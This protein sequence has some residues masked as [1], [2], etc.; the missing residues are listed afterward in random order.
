MYDSKFFF[1]GLCKVFRH[2]CNAYILESSSLFCVRRS[3]SKVPPEI[4][5]I[6]IIFITGCFN[7]HIST[8]LNGSL[9]V[10]ISTHKHVVTCSKVDTFLSVCPNQY[11]NLEMRTVCYTTSYNLW[12]YIDN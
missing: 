5:V 7:W 2:S 9:Q 6:Y 3:I 12:L 11:H 8:G 10:Q 1:P 4:T